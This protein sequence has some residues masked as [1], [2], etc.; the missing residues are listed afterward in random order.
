MADQPGT[1][2]DRALFVATL[3]AR[4]LGHALIVRDA[5]GSTNDDAF[6]AL[7][8][9]A[10]DG[11][12]VVADAQTKGRGRAG[13][14]WTHAP[15]RALALSTAL[16]LGCDVRQAGLVPL[17]AG[18]AAA[19]A[20]ARCGVQHARLKWP[21]DVLV[22]GRKLAGVLCELRRAPQG[23]DVVVIGV[24]VNVRTRRDEFPAELQGTATSVALERGDDAVG[25]ED[26]AARLLEALE[27][28]WE[29]LQ[30]GDRA[31]IRDAW[32]AR[33]AFWGES[34][35]VRAPGGDVTGVAQRLDDDGGLVLRLESGIERVMIAGDVEPA[36]CRA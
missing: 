25:V 17:A 29:Q 36:E 3:R 18:L 33:A 34:V 32:S 27:P 2:F 12:V 23:G 21:N 10:G 16:H 14:T 20:A 11:V 9:G 22:H 30:E 6:D 8:D 31:A 13:R 28:L 7:C 35:T 19:T 5:T 4:R 26:V 1:G 24:G 15:G